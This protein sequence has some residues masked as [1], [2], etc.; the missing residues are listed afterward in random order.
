LRLRDTQNSY[1]LAILT[2][3]SFEITRPDNK[4]FKL[5]ANNFESIQYGSGDSGSS[6]E[7]SPLTGFLSGTSKV[8]DLYYG[9]GNSAA[10]ENLVVHDLTGNDRVV[11]ENLT[12][13]GGFSSYFSNGIANSAFTFGDGDISFNSKINQGYYATAVSGGSLSMGF[14][15]SYI[16][17]QAVEDFPQDRLGFYY[18]VTGT[19]NWTLDAGNGRDVLNVVVRGSKTE[20]FSSYGVVSGSIA[21]GGGNDIANVTVI[22]LSG[23]GESIGIHNVSKFDLG[24]GNNRATVIST[25]YGVK[26]STVTS[27][28]GVD[29]L[30]VTSNL[31]AI[32]NTTISTGD[33]D[34]SLFA[35]SAGGNSADLLNTTIDLGGGDDYID[36]RIAIDSTIDGGIGYDVLRLRDTESSYSITDLADGAVL[37]KRP[38]DLFFNLVVNNVEQIMYGASAI[39][40][41]YSGSPLTGFLSGTL[42]GHDTYYG[43]GLSAAIKNL[44]VRDTEGNDHVIAENL[45]SSGRAES[46]F[47][48]AIASSSFAF[49]DGYISFAAKINHGYYATAFDDGDL[50][51][52]SGDSRVDIQAVEDYPEESFGFIYGVTGINSVD[53]DAGDGQ[54]ILNVV[55]SANRNEAFASKG[56][57]AGK[58]ALGEGHDLVNVSITNLSGTRESVA[59]FGATVELGGGDDVMT[60]YSTGS[61][62]ISSSL[63]GQDGNDF[64]AVRSNL[65]ALQSTNV[66]LG[67]GDDKLFLKSEDVDQIDLV[68]S[69]INMGVGDDYVEIRSGQN[70]TING[71]DGY[72]TIRLSGLEQNYTLEALDDGSMKVFS[73]VH[74][75]EALSLSGFE[76]IVF[77]PTID[78]GQ[79]TFEVQGLAQVYQTLSIA[80]VI[81]DPEGFASSEMSYQWQSSMDGFI[82]FNVG[83]NGTFTIR[84]QD[85]DAMLRGVVSYFDLAGNY[86]TVSSLPTSQIIAP[87]QAPAPILQA[88]NTLISSVYALT[89]ETSNV[90]I[91]NTEYTGVFGN[92]NN[93]EIEANTMGNHLDG[94]A[95]DDRLLGNVGVDVLVGGEGDDWIDGGDGDDLIIGGSGPGDDV[96]TGG[97]GIDTVKYTSATST[98]LINLELGIANGVD[99]DNDTLLSIEN[100]IGGQSDDLIIGDSGANKL[101]GYTGDDALFGGLGNDFIDGGAGLDYASFTGLS[102]QYSIQIGSNTTILDTESSRD[103][104]DSLINVERLIF[105]DTNIA[106]DFKET[107]GQ[108]YR[109]Y[110]A[111]LGRAPDLEG[112]G[113]WINDMDNGVS[114]TTIA[115][116]FI[117]SLEFQG[118]YGANPSYETYINLLYNNILERDPDPDGLNYWVSNMQNDVDT[119]AAVLASFSEGFENTANVAPDI[120]NGIYY[121]AWIT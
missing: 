76:R 44:I 103:G 86:C 20:T 33:G 115:Q 49:G 37:I 72:D 70:S 109:I 83:S 3:T 90:S 63:S 65:G 111:V 102:S 30:D 95:G 42:A 8:N 55:V 54:D 106:L 4:F 66:N 27:G 50:T 89:D 73:V 61:G 74:Q 2:D 47:C 34:D 15:G 19:S 87:T 71:G 57:N 35:K 39:K 68:T 91:V 32:S 77:G 38:Q 6:Y 107:A 114:L 26:G 14:G 11:A 25:G 92:A 24:D 84:E 5:I 64:L 80:M 85:Q 7:G 53:F 120:A 59:I 41:Y 104:T 17:I 16:N 99:I 48:S 97:N 12:E 101:D 10:I 56:I 118:K 58:Y 98:L 46:Y 40:P 105:A 31:D 22:N 67:Q 69:V 112:L 79:A 121:T 78:L 45:S 117:A 96:Y 1:S 52:G 9:S 119:P 116:G 113:Y 60:V 88:N 28:N 18:S 110:E 62:I 93:N 100:I 75:T 108:A 81:A 36:V 43:S 21:L 23:T 51:M 13:T 94:G 29:V 82:W